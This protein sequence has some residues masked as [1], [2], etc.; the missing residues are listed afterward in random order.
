MG[1]DLAVERITAIEKLVLQSGELSRMEYDFLFDRSSHLLAIVYNV[2][3]RWRDTS[4]YDLLASEA[5]LCSFIGIAQGQL[6]QESW[7]ALGRMLAIAG[8]GPVLRG[9]VRC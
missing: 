1:N 8:G 2:D 7:F 4:Y 3:S 5:R 6:P 9:A